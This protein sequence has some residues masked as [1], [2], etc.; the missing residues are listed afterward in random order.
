MGN[1]HEP[2]RQISSSVENMCTITV[3]QKNEIL[4][5]ILTSRRSN[6]M[7]HPEVPPDDMIRG[8]I[9]AGLLAPFAAA[10]IGGT[11]KEYFRQFFVI[12]NGSNSMAE[13]SKLVMSKIHRMVES[14]EE[15]MNNNPELKK[16]VDTFAKRLD[17]IT[18][19]GKV[20]GIGTAPYYIVVA[21][22]RGYPSVERQSLA[23]C[24]EN[25]WLKATALGLGFQLVSVTSEM[26]DDK[27]F[28]DILGVPL[29]KYELMGCAVGYAQTPLPPSVRPPVNDVTKWLT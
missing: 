3:V 2:V 20:P 15:D 26:S 1:L 23:H 18:S 11:G 24:L 4:D 27:K 13:A 8:I 7:F 28:C 21:E 19:S 16:S 22:L 12:K 25:M 6:R 10:A 14:V 17:M 9:R 5:E 29:G